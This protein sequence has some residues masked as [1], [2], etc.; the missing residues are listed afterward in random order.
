[1]F[2]PAMFKQFVLPALTE[3]CERLDYSLYHLDGTQCIC[4]LDI[5]LEIDALDAIEWTPQAGIEGGGDPRWYDMYKKILAAGKSVQ[6]IGI[7]VN[8]VEQVLDAVGNEGVYLALQ[9][10][11]ER[12][13][14]IMKRKIEAYR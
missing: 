1:M 14:G 3:Q 11:D 12:E 4:N 9:M 10:A 5:L 6:I 7:D 13:A 2:S 8:N